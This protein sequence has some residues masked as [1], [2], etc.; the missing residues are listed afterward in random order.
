MRV[1][2]VSQVLWPVTEDFVIGEED[3]HG[4]FQKLVAT[5]TST[6]LAENRNSCAFSKFCWVWNCARVL[7]VGALFSENS[8]S[9]V[10]L[11]VFLW[12]LNCF[13]VVA[14]AGAVFYENLPCV[15]SIDFEGWQVQCSCYARKHNVWRAWNFPGW[16][17]IIVLCFRSCEDLARL[18]LPTAHFG[19]WRI[20]V[21]YEWAIL[22]TIS[23]INLVW[24]SEKILSPRVCG[25]VRLRH[26]Q[27]NSNFC[28]WCHSGPRLLKEYLSKSP[29]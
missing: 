14:C 18:A 5:H 24:T 21:V 13:V 4:A 19:K 12:A 17:I 10:I 8:K 25:F 23:R 29:L 11:E 9:Y 27:P 20:M 3:G 26:S 6:V 15:F 28:F 1:A 22:C 16:F 2:K 7:L